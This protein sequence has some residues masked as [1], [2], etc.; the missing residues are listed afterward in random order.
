MFKEAEFI[1]QCTDRGLDET[2]ILQSRS[3]L[4]ELELSF[5]GPSTTLETATLDEVERRIAQMAGTSGCRE[6][7]LT[8]LARYFSVIGRDRLAIRLFAYLLPVGVLPAMAGRLRL[9]KGN[10]VAD[11]VLAGLAF[12]PPGT[13]PELYPAATAAFVAALDRE[14]GPEE[15]ERILTWNVH[16]IPVSVF[17]AERVR[18]VAL[19]SIDAW[20]KDYHDRQVAKLARHASD[21]TLWFEQKISNAVVEFVKANQEIQGGV[22]KGNTIFVTKIPYDPDRFLKETDPLEKRRLTCHCPLA[23]SSIAEG[24]AGVPASWCACSAG[25]VK[26]IFD[27]VFAVETKATVVSSVLKGDPICRFAIQ[28]PEASVAPFL[29]RSGKGPVHGGAKSLKPF[30][31][32][33]VKTGCRHDDLDIHAQFLKLPRVCQGGFP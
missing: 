26:F 12:P 3:V 28:I 27:V 24:G 22:R 23:A 1:A 10:V 18:L 31:V 14:L 20:L 13:A 19:G 25:F 9:L 6:A 15:T 16:G 30:H 21:G 33:T 11:S 29:E 2:A 7:D 32:F 17:A 8:T 5:S 4:R